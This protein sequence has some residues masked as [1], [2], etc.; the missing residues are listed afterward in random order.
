MAW[1]WFVGAALV[2][3]MSVACALTLGPKVAK[4]EAFVWQPS[5]FGWAVGCHGALGVLAMWMLMQA[6]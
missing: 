5:I 3:M 2:V 4:G 6:R 1:L